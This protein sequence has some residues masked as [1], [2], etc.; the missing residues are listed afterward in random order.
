MIINGHS[1][2]I[3]LPH[4]MDTGGYGLPNEQQ[5][6]VVCFAWLKMRALGLK[7]ARSIISIGS[8]EFG[9]DRLA[10]YRVLNRTRKH[11]DRIGVPSP[12]QELDSPCH[13][14]AAHLEEAA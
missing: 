5:F 11:F 1:L 2:K 9:L 13:R 8:D 7:P 10:V 14:F 12:A 4:M 6:E 3:C